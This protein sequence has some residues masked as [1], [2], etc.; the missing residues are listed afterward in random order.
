MNAR[1]RPAPALLA[2]AV[3]AAHSGC[4]SVGPQESPHRPSEETRSRFGRVGVTWDRSGD[5]LGGYVPARGSLDGAG[6][7]AVAGMLVDLKITLGLTAGSAAMGEAGPFLAAGFL[8]LGLFMLPVSALIGSI[9]GAAAAPDSKTVDEAAEVLRLAIDRREFARGVA[10]TIL[11]RGRACLDDSL[12]EVEPGSMLD[13]FQTLLVVDPPLFTLVGPYN[14]N[15][16]LQLVLQQTVTLVRTSDHRV[17]YRNTL[18]HL[19]PTK[20]VYLKWAKNDAELLRSALGD[21]DRALGERLLGEIFLL[22]P[23]PSNRE[24][25]KVKT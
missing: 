21:L 19:V 13:G 20:A 3:L 17:L 12:E 22:H 9:Y 4:A 8:G 23:L 2:A 7:G 15:P 5:G 11:A 6:R 14:V 24:W 10:R 16:E 1:W 25:K 18:H